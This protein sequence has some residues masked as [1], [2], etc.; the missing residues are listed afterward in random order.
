MGDRKSKKKLYKEVV[1]NSILQLEHYKYLLEKI[2]SK[3]IDLS[4]NDILQN[5]NK[6]NENDHIGPD[7]NVDQFIKVIRN[8]NTVMFEL[9]RINNIELNEFDLLDTPPLYIKS[10]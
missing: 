1:Y 7:A 9:G 5:T 4:K 2:S 8:I 6:P 10:I 3:A